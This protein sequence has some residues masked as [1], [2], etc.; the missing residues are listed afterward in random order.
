[1]KMLNQIHGFTSKVIRRLIFHIIILSYCTRLDS[2]R[3]KIMKQ[4]IRERKEEIAREE[5][6]ENS[7]G[8][9]GEI[10]KC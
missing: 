2:V 8:D 10:S 5:I 6:K 7:D 1:M 4:V 9:S 3:L